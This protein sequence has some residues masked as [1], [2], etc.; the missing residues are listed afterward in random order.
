MNTPGSH[1]PAFHEGEQRFDLTA[2]SDL[3]HVKA[4]WS[5][6]HRPNAVNDV[7]DRK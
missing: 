4:R 5:S 2:P 1:N 6:A 3:L 7:S